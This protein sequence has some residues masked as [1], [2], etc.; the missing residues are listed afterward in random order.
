MKVFHFF[1]YLLLYPLAFAAISLQ[2]VYYLPLAWSQ[3][4]WNL[5]PI[6]LSVA[7]SYLLANASVDKDFPFIKITI[8]TFY[9]VFFN[10]IPGYLYKLG[11][12]PNYFSYQPDVPEYMF[13]FRLAI[14]S[15]ICYEIGSMFSFKSGGSNESLLADR[16]RISP[17]I[18]Y[19]CLAI[20]VV[21]ILMFM[22]LIGNP[23]LLVA[24]RS[25]FADY[26]DMDSSP[27]SFAIVSSLTRVPAF[28]AAAIL[29]ML[30]V[31][32]NKVT[33]APAFPL[34]LFC[35]L[36]LSI[37][38]NFPTAVPRFWLGSM[39]YCIALLYI[40]NARNY[41]KSL[42]PA[43]VMFSLL[44]AFPF[45]GI[46]RNYFSDTRAQSFRT[47]VLDGYSNG[48]YDIFTMLLSVVR[49]VEVFGHT[50]GK[51]TLG[52]LLFWVP[53]AV[54]P[55][56]PYG[57][58]YM[59]A[60]ELQF[61]FFNLASPLLSEMYIDFGTVGVAL[62]FALFG[63]AISRQERLVSRGAAT[64]VRIIVLAFVAGWMVILQRGSLNIAIASLVPFLVLSY[65]ISRMFYQHV[66]S[67][68]SG[69]TL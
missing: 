30:I 25:G 53:R 36:P 55:N 40:I 4:E 29:F 22:V 14:I 11:Y 28:M 1:A 39:V 35:T 44:V 61:T 10:I 58:G 31:T 68:R 42:Y 34:V 12:T 6:A 8:Y 56:K 65:A 38:A 45:S 33:N 59:V 60:Q 15:I 19:F 18:I 43:F 17:Y 51:Q 32:R 2:E 9:Y 69:G 66:T 46:L 64:E 62:S 67:M 23:L 20:A 5:E 41:L 7:I 16:K 27:A 54:Y 13:G 52:S 26:F 24:D 50:Y 3:F 63:F 47:L 48:Q 37:L 21:S 57:T 49:Y